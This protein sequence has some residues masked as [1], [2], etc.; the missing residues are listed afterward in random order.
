[1][2]RRCIVP[3]GSNQKGLSRA[4]R[5]RI[6]TSGAVAVRSELPGRADMTISRR[7][8]LAGLGLAACSPA[9]AQTRSPSGLRIRTG[10]YATDRSAFK[11]RAYATSFKAPARLLYG[12]KEEFYRDNTR[13]TA[14]LARDAGKDV[15]A[16]EVA[17]D[18]F[19][20]VPEEISRAIAFF[21]ANA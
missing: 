13:L 2:I 4:A 3:I 9:W 11:T 8:L 12:R 1:L 14:A 18:H 15:A 5:S 7:A 19:N 21:R 16:V 10:D 17:G 20:A 6:A